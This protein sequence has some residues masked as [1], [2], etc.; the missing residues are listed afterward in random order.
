[1]TEPFFL[2]ALAAAIGLALITAP[3]G[4]FIVWNRM[5][6]FGETIAHAG[7][8]G[9]ALGLALNLDLTFSVLL[10]TAAIA[11]VIVLLTRQRAVPADSILGLMHYSALAG[12]VIATAALSGRANDLVGY[13]FGDI[14]AVTTTDL[15]WIYAGGAVVLSAI[16][17]LWQP[18]VRLSV[19]EELARAE[20][21]P[22]PQMR[23]AFTL[24]LALTI[25][26]A[27]KIVGILLFVAFLI[28]PA[29]AAR[30][31]VSTPERMVAVAALIGVIG[32]NLGLAASWTWNT[33]GGPAIVLVLSA[34][35]AL[36]LLMSALR[37]H[38]N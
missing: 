25:A 15:Y 17:F 28:I 32:V 6:Y 23:A 33:S 38:G 3:L 1:M 22:E 24:V 26:I 12:G 18:L 35:A 29:V 9:I 8:L 4:C 7:L 37:D 30:P 14:F 31:F 16:A 2:R 13:L 20:G 11:A 36:S 27:V 5:A 19:N 10:I 21:V 34:A